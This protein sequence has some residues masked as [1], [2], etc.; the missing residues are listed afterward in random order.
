MILVISMRNRKDYDQRDGAIGSVQR[1][2][3]TVAPGAKAGASS[4]KRRAGVRYSL[5]RRFVVRN[6]S[7]MVSARRIFFSPPRRTIRTS[8]LRSRL[9]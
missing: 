3:P 2:L 4:V 9:L 6:K 1:G 8:A 5:V 7:R